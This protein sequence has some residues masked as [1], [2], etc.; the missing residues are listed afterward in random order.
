MTLRNIF[1]Q[2]AN[3]DI[4]QVWVLK[5]GEIP[6]LCFSVGDESGRQRLF[7]LGGKFLEKTQYLEN[8]FGILID[9]NG[10]CVYP[11]TRVECKKKI[12]FDGKSAGFVFFCQFEIFQA[13]QHQTTE[14]HWFRVVCGQKLRDLDKEVCGY[15]C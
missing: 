6:N 1:L 11:K 4:F 12:S 8:P 10:V 2:G 13:R 7:I 9:S 15:R 5:V 14:T 3:L